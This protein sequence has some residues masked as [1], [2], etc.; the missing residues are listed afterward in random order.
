LDAFLEKR[1]PSRKK[2]SGQP[3]LQLVRKIPLVK[4]AFVLAAREPQRVPSPNVEGPSV[5]KGAPWSGRGQASNQPEDQPANLGE[6]IE[7]R[8]IFAPFGGVEL[9][10]PPREPIP[11]SRIK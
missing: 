10:I 3:Q 1:L 4:P 7:I 8:K 5:R 9:K 2:V 11:E 6:D